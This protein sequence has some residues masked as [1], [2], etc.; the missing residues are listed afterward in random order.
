MGN[1]T[2]WENEAFVVVRKAYYI[3]VPGLYFVLRKYP[4]P[5]TSFLE[6]GLYAKTIK[7]MRM[8]LASCDVHM[9]G[10]YFHSNR[11]GEAYVEVIP[12]HVSA[13]KEL[14]IPLD[15]YQPHIERYLAY[16]EPTEKNEAE[17]QRY[18]V[19]LKIFADTY[20]SGEKS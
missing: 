9:A 12:Y 2:V 1:M 20:F 17:C 16:Y 3:P 10:I 13:L 8:F 15:E 18:D 7:M 11:D 6:I 14:G 19:A 5:E 4:Q